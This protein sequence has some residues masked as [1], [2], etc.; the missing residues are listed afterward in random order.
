MLL[1][2]LI[3]AAPGLLRAA[4][5]EP[6]LGPMAVVGRLR[7]DHG[8][9]WIVQPL[10]GAPVA[11]IE[12][13]YRAPSTGFGPKPMPS[14]ARLAAQTV[15]A[16]KPLV[17]PSLSRVVKDSGG[18]LGITVYS[19]TLEIA[20]VV[21]SNFAKAVVKT[22]TTVYFAPVVN[23]AGLAIARRDVTQEALLESF[24]PETLTRE[25]VF[26][27][28]FSE[29]P[30][31][32]PALGDPKTVAAITLAETRSFATR[33]FRSQNAIL[34]VSGAIDPSIAT[35][36]ATGRPAQ[37]ALAE[38]ENYSPL[39][40]ATVSEPVVKP[41]EES[42]G[43]YGWIGPS[44][45]DERAATALDF[46]SDY[47][48]G[49]ETGYV[50]RAI[51]DGDPDAFVVGQFITLHDPGVL[52]VGYSAKQAEAL[53]SKIDEAVNLVR[54][55]LP[56]ATFAAALIT[57]RYRLLHDLQTPSEIAD[58]LGWY[59]VEGNPEYAP[60]ANGNRGK[61]FQAL[62]SLTPDYVASVAERYL[63]KRG[64]AVILQP[65]PKPSATR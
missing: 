47:L 16:S 18:R 13:W 29:G 19:D 44:I 63:A 56:A 3:A 31:H 24:N 61:Y 22:L 2:A 35:S 17:G 12:L 36:A 11:A 8:G 4:G 41:F 59:V 52:F 27:A 42:G 7:G 25:A 58:N 34:V 45:A 32:Y 57:F 64:V 51:A 5:G 40:V 60:G 10:R 14:L 1:A 39:Q 43:G 65:V 37:G 6:N 54:K 9:L 21:P 15:A 38:H 46:I 49:S 62:D 55:P 50:N 23:E 33:A 20:A 48:F 30:Q 28:L 26:T 53:R